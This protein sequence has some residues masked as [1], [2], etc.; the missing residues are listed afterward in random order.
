VKGG[1]VRKLKQLLDDN[2]ETKGYW[3]LK[4]EVVDCTLEKL[5]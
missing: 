5:I 3:N 1:G 2:K 4:D